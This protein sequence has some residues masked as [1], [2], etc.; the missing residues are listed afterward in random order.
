MSNLIVSRKALGLI[1]IGVMGL[2]LRNATAYTYNPPWTWLGPAPIPNGQTTTQLQSVSGRVTTIAVHPTNENIAYVG[3]AQGGVYR[4][5]DG[6]STWTQLLDDNTATLAIGSLTLAPSDPTTL[7]VG[8]GEPYNNLDGYCG[9]GLY[10]ITNADTT[11]VVS[12]PFDRNAANANAFDGVAISRIIVS[13]TDPNT[14]LVSS[15]GA[16]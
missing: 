12:G 7:F 14:I 5:L 1:A 2:G 10:V 13:S 11:A 4:T 8:T 3:T 6:G 16:I 15:N 9:V